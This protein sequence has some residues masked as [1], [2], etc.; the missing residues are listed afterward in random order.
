MAW[1][2]WQMAVSTGRGWLGVPMQLHTEFPELVMLSWAPGCQG[3]VASKRPSYSQRILESQ[4]DVQ[5][6]TGF[7]SKPPRPL[8]GPTPQSLEGLCPV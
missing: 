6:G 2:H 3:Q 8:W 5:T 1:P 4:G 7:I